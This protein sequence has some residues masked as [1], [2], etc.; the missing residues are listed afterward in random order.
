VKRRNHLQLTLLSLM[1]LALALG[2]GACSTSK[3]QNPVS[4]EDVGKVSESSDTNGEQKPTEYTTKAGDSLRK[5]AGRPEVYGD[6][7]MWPILAEANADAVGQGTSVNKGVLLKIP[8]DI[9]TDQIEEAH[10]KARQVA[11][12]LKMASRPAKVAEPTQAVPTAMPSHEAAPT[13]VPP[14]PV[15]QVKKSG[16]LLPVLFILL[17]ILAALAVILFFFMKKESKEEHGE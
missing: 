11:A 9:T 14:Q 4:G 13:P 6:P 2:M 17:L 7:N 10:E 12:E 3:N 5:I 1:G 16:V 8:R 15:P